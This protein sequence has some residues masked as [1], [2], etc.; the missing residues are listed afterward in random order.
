MQLIELTDEEL[1]LY[2]KDQEDDEIFAQRS[3]E[4]YENY[5]G[6]YVTIVEGELFV[7]ETSLDIEKQVQMKYPNRLP[8]I[9]FIPKKR[10]VRIYVHLG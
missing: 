10:G 8:C 7:G 5:K 2:L 3:L 9:Q 6:K 4:L 1:A